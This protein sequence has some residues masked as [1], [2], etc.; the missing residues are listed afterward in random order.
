MTIE[1]TS[2]MPAQ[3]SLLPSSDELAAE[4]GGDIGAQ[5]AAMVLLAARDNRNAAREAQRAEEANLFEQQRAEVEAMHAQAD[6]TRSAALD[7]ARGKIFAGSADIGAALVI[8]PQRAAALSALG[9]LGAGVQDLRASQHDFQAAEHSAD[10]TRA[11]NLA[12]ASARRLDQLDSVIDDARDLKNDALS[13]LRGIR[14]TENQTDE[15]AIF[16]RG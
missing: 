6:A 2:T 15:A 12:E 10:A 13:F 9:D 11:G 16:L 4:L 5:V 3:Y 7:A 1:R 8:D 14:Q